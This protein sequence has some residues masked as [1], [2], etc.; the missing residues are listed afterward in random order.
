MPVQHVL[1]NNLS[2]DK[3]SRPV[4][5]LTCVASETLLLVSFCKGLIST[6]KCRLA[7]FP[8]TGLKT[9]INEE[10]QGK[11]GNIPRD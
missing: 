7:K 10:F 2:E 3:T 1:M 11:R 5:I 6:E 8:L 9:Q 4:S